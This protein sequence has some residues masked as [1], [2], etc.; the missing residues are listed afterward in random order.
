MV[1]AP[2]VS[3]ASR[4]VRLHRLLLVAGLATTFAPQG[5][6]PALDLVIQRGTIIDGSGGRRFT[7]D[8]GVIN[9]HIAAIGDLS[10]RRA[11]ATIDARG[12]I[13]APGFINLHSHAT[14]DGLRVAENMLTQGVTTEI[15][16]ADGAGPLDIVAQLR[17][18]DSSGI[19]INAGA[20][21]GFNAVWANVVGQADRRPTA[22]EIERMRKIID[23]NLEEGAFS[24]SAG[25]DYKPGYYATEDEVV[26][27]LEPARRWRTNFPNHDRVIPDTKF[28][29][30]AAVQETMRIGE[31]SGLVP[32]VTHM[33][34][35]G[36]EKGTANV[37]LGQMRANIARGVYTAA[38]VYPYLSGLTGL[39]ALTIPAWAVDG[40]PIEMRKRFADPALRQR[41]I[42]ETDETIAA[43]FTGADGILVLS[44]RRT[45]SDY[46]KEFA[47][48][49]PGE[50]IVR[51]METDSP[52]AILGFGQE[53]DLK[54]ILQYPASAISCDCGATSEPTG[55][56]RNY[57]TFPRV[58]GR[59]VREQR[60]LTWEDAIRKMTALPATISGFADR[61]Y[62][63]VGMAADITIFDSAKVMDH[64]T[65]DQPGLRSEGIRH[66][67]VNGE[68]ALRDGAS[69]GVKAGRTLRR[70]GW[71]PSRPMNAAT[72]AR[73]FT[74][75]G[76]FTPTGQAEPTHQVVINLTQAAGAR[77]ATGTFT[78]TQLDDGSVLKG[79]TYG[80]IQTSKGWTSVTGRSIWNP[81]HEERSFTLTV[82]DADPHM[83]RGQ[84]TVTFEV[85]GA[86][87]VRGVLR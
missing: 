66:V 70:H 7:G 64:A 53:D 20:N 48:S 78:S 40:G 2:F 60:V 29:A 71:M 32:V 82:D 36:R 49:S 9:G 12:L 13:V 50:A 77:H 75:R 45:L 1:T 87:P 69:T 16:N 72:S 68:V 81:R 4:I 33:K 55:H 26:T 86:P 35:S 79:Q 65:F 59:Y 8:I 27:V 73:R 57:G 51:I 58:L 34:V 84:K 67:I 47:T 80:V 5:Q 14:P 23:D 6:P 19:A 18:L 56:P 37:I 15:L 39:G 44:T 43:R 76:R 11:T 3:P 38:D 30:R 22:D 83:P 21:I 61:G 42:A 54:K 17:M 63:A 74:L 52:R 10:S 28:S 25:L 31:R 85:D 46:M 24:V 62:L 41:I